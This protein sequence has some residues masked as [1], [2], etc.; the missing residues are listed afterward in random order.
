MITTQIITHNNEKTIQKTLE[1][2]LPLQGKITIVD[3]GSTDTTLRIV[4]KFGANVVPRITG[5]RSYIRNQLIQPGWNFY[6]EPW[7]V[8]I[9]VFPIPEQPRSCLFQVISDQTLIKEARLWHDSTHIRFNNPICESLHDFN[10]K[11]IENSIIFSNGHSELSESALDSWANGSPTL[12]TP[13][14]YRAFFYLQSQKYKEF[15]RDANQFLFLGGTGIPAYTMKYY[16]SLVHLY[17]FN[18][19]E[20]AIKNMII[21][22]SANILMAEFWCLLGDA[23]YKLNQYAKAYSLYENAIILGERRLKSDPWPMDIPKYKSYPR[24]MMQS[25]KELLEGEKF[26]IG[27][28]K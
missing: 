2:I 5:D 16:L 8:L 7:E 12:S 22:L 11:F 6:I 20:I 27:T 15:I 24:K 1:S 28:K 3:F 10:S 23:F 4:E 17:V 9:N 25:C 26:L 13:Y 21:C 14:Y 18:N 19:V